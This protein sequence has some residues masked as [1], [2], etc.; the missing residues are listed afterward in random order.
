M[1]TL[2]DRL[3]VE[4]FPSLEHQILEVNADSVEDLL[5]VAKPLTAGQS[6]FS[7]DIDP[8]GR[9]WVATGPERDRREQARSRCGSREFQI[10]DRQTQQ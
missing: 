7:I 2:R 8:S 6:R 9:K 10:V 1:R 4:R 3:W 5:A